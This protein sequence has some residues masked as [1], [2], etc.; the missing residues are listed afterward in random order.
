M[1]RIAAIIALCSALAASAASSAADCNRACLK[2]HLDTYLAGVA[3][4]KPEAAGLWVGF[5]QTENSVAIPEGQ[6]ACGS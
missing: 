5:R 3:G 1:K 4:H 2:K 6:G